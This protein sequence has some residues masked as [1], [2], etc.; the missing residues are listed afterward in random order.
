[1][2]YKM[3]ISYH[4]IQLFSCIFV[5]LWINAGNFSLVVDKV[6]A[7]IKLG[8]VGM[9]FLFTYLSGKEFIARFIK[10][11]WPIIIFD[12]LLFFSKLMGHSDFYNQYCQ[13]YIYITI[14]TLFYSYY[15]FYGKRRDLE[16]ILTI[17]AID[18]VIVI[19]RTIA[20][21]LQNPLLARAISTSYSVALSVLGTEKPRG[22]GGYGLCY[23]LVILT[24]FTAYLFSRDNKKKAIKYAFLAMCAIFLF[25]AQIT[26]AAIMFIA[27]Y[28]VSQFFFSNQGKYAFLKRILIGILAIVII[29]YSDNIISFIIPYAG[30]ELGNRLGELRA[31][32]QYGGSSTGDLATRFRLYKESL[33]AFASNPIWGSFGN[34]PFGNHSTLFDLL[35]AYGILG[36]VGYAG[37]LRPQLNATYVFRKKKMATV[38]VITI[39]SYLMLSIVN[40]SVGSEIMVA[41][42][43]I[44]PLGLRLF[45]RVN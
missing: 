18:I 33:D 19:I 26:M 2:K 9:W 12:F 10:I 37:L 29:I 24:P 35:A 20:A 23:E 32:I 42:I 36:M 44:V 25:Q 43:I 39:I 22:I 17:L 31:V 11:G 30:S 21:L 27:I 7:V 6:P 16:L 34:K 1:M 28:I 13:I 38:I 41:F 40:I 15:F 8:T 4:T 5:L 3:R 45:D 14:L